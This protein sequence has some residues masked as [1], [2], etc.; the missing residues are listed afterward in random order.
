[1]RA[2]QLKRSLIFRFILLNK[3]DHFTEVETHTLIAIYLMNIDYQRCSGNTLFKYLSKIHR[4]PYRKRL[5]LTL[6]NFKETGIIRLSGKGPGTNLFLTEHGK[7]YLFDLERK[8]K[9]IKY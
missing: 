5:L 7:Q 2:T 4:T 6:R 8:L 9:G 1:M 3:I